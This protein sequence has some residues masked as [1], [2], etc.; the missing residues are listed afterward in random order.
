MQ[1]S[2]SLNLSLKL[3]SSH[4]KNPSSLQHIIKNRLIIHLLL[5]QLIKNMRKFMYNMRKNTN[6]LDT[7]RLLSN[8]IMK[9][10]FN[11]KTST[12]KLRSDKNTTKE[13]RPISK[14]LPREVKK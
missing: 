11:I 1:E 14:S 5:N 2:L 3:S 4:L 10:L 9:Q 8:T 6:S 7:M 12:K 13:S